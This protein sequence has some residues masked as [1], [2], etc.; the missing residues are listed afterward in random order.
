MSAIGFFFFAE[1]NHSRCETD[2]LPVFIADVNPLN[3]E[4]NP[5]CQ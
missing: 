1:V 2:H 4:L 3:T 5:I